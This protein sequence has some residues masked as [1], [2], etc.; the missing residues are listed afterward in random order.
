MFIFLFARLEDCTSSAEDHPV[1]PDECP[2]PAEDDPG[3]VED[4]PPQWELYGNA[5]EFT[6]PV[7]QGR[8]KL[9]TNIPA[10]I[11]HSPEGMST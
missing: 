5:V 2:G 9:S 3:S 8:R 4:D 7:T 6:K 10:D 1:G 11:K